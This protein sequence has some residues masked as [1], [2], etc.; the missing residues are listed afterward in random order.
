V[1][2]GRG[3][4]VGEQPDEVRSRTVRSDEYVPRGRPGGGVVRGRGFRDSPEE[5]SSGRVAIVRFLLF[6]LGLAA[7]V[8]VFLV[9]VGGPLLGD[10]VYGFATSRPETMRYPFV[11]SIVQQHLGADLTAPG[12]TDTTEVRFTIDSGTTA[13]QIGQKLEDAG[14]VRNHVA[15]VYLVVTENRSS[16]IETGTY[17]LN[18]TMTP[19]QILDALQAAPV[20]TVTIFLREG[21]RLEQIVAYLKTLPLQTDIAR[22]YELASHPPATLLAEFSWL[23]IPAGRSLEGFLAPDTYQVWEDITPTDLIRLLVNNYHKQLG[24]DLLQR[25]AASGRSLY[26]VVTLA[27]L[28][29][30]EAKLDEERPIIAGVFQN[31]INR[32]MLLNAD[33]TVI[34]AKD[35]VE[36]AKLPLDDWPDFYFWAQIKG[37]LAS[38]AVPPELAGYQ[39]YQKRGLPPGP[40]CTPRVLSVEA[41]L[42]PDTSTGYLYF[43]AIPDG[44]GAHAF[45]KT[46]KEHEANLKKYGYGT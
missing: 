7:A 12:G 21:L 17:R 46:L 4:P 10:T 1:S 3:R 15:F 18:A 20:K 26:E 2:Y 29:D 33:P 23:D 28:V 24:D 45:A 30:K 5:R 38:F 19:Q 39:T 32:K 40:I 41:A 8:I 43:V 31:R 42:A 6:V 11:A 13:A 44:S 14:L 22:F 25:I 16:A 27:S 34:Y 9:T 37:P 35:S 36:L